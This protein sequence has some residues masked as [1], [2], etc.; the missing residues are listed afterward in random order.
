MLL[1]IE[2]FRRQARKNL[3]R[4]VFDYVEGAAEDERCRDRNGANLQALQ[5]VPTCLRDTSTIDTSLTVFGQRWNAPLGV[6][7][8][9][10]CGLV[11]PQ[12]DKFLARAAASRGLPFVLSTASNTRLEAVREAAPK[13]L[14]WMQLYV[15]SD[16]AIAE[17][18]IRRARE[19]NYGALVLTVDVPVSG[20]R[21]RDVR[22]G[23]KLPFR[24]TLRT[25]ANLACHPAWLLRVARYG[26]PSFVNLAESQEAA[27]SA[28][29]Q[30]ALLARAMDRRL[31][32]ESL[33]WIR[34]LWDGPLLIKGLLHADD[35]A[36]ALN[37]GVDGLIV[38]N[39]GGR[40]LDAAV[41]TIDALPAIADK[42]GARVPVFVDS[43]FRRGSD[44]A[45]AL[46]LGASAVFVGR[47]AVYGMA[48]G[49]EAGARA[50]LQLLSDELERTMTLLGAATLSDIAPH[51]LFAGS[52]P[53]F[54][55]SPT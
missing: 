25:L 43:G 49:G 33:A 9:G 52:T 28:Q 34:S 41:A 27:A 31:V 11:H 2:D 5:L 39:H 54:A 15:M 50:V 1:N 20:Y 53:S 17:Q 38:S 46:A 26:M 13:G 37:H 36:R 55:W 21:E 10:F 12:G 32:W 42:V 47:P 14:Q 29:V 24:P 48:C 45:K 6:A 30:A 4:F 8:V 3:P 19:A 44:I 22:N 18:L 40:Q 7:P 35:A 16:R 51:H 23:F